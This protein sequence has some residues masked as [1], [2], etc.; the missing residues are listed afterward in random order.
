MP[1]ANA[2]ATIATTRMS[3]R[4]RPH[5]EI[6]TPVGQTDALRVPRFAGIR[7][8]ARLPRQQDV[9]RPEVAILG[10]PFDGGTTFRTGSRFGPAAIREA[11]LLLRPYNEPLEVAPFEVAQAVDAG[12]AAA[13]PIDIAAAHAAIQEA[14]APLH[15]GGCSV[16]GLGGDHSV[17]LPLLRAAA[18][19]HGPLSL[20]QLDAHT[21]TWDSYF[22]SKVTHGTIFKR[23]AEEGVIDASS[24]IQVGLRGSLYSE[25]DLAD[26]QALGFSTLLARHLDDVGVEGALG[27]IADTVSTPVYVSV[28]VDVLD[29]AFAPGT[30][31]PEAGGLTSRELLAIVRGLDQIDTRIAAADVVEVSPPYDPSGVTALAAANVA[32]DLIGLLARDRAENRE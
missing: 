6:D 10:V 22:G 23:A 18:E 2:T 7:T 8:F 9:E 25:H 11:S 19:V 20:I 24:S 16:L 21:D 32:Y 3:E 27:L 28:D 5:T 17:S 12:D 1:V 30:G 15:K 31:T 13:S 26:H 14:A 4:E 29:P